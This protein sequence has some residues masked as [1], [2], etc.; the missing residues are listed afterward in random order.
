MDQ[1]SET[2]VVG[3][4][5]SKVGKIYDFESNGLADLKVGDQ[6]V[7]ETSRGWQLGQV[8]QIIVNVEPPPEGWKAIDRRA[9]PRDLLL[10]QMWQQHEAE[11]VTHAKTR[12]GELRLQGIKIIGAE[13][14]FDGS[15]LT[16]LFSSE[17]EEKYELKSLRQDMQ[18]LFA[19]SQVEMRQIG[20]RDVAKLTCGM[21]ACGLEKR[22]CCSFLTEFSSISIRM[23]KEQG[24]SLTP[25]EI[26]GMCGRLR[27]CLIYEYET[28]VDA[29]QTLPKRNKRVRTPKGEGKVIDVAPL[30][31]T[32]VVDLPEVGYTEFPLS[33]IVVLDEKGEPAPASTAG[34]P[35]MSPGEVADVAHSGPEDGYTG[36]A[37]E[38]RPA[39]PRSSR[40]SQEERI[41]LDS[42]PRV[43][44]P[45]KENRSQREPR[46][47]DERARGSKGSGGGRGREQGGP[48]RDQ[49]NRPARDPGSSQRGEGGQRRDAGGAQP[50]AGNA[51]RGAGDAQRDPGN[52]QRDAG[53]SQRG[54]GGGRSDSRRGPRRSG[55][56]QNRGPQG[57][58]PQAG[59][60]AN[61]GQDASEK[62]PSTDSG[63][64]GQAG[65]GPQRPN[66]A[67]R[68]QGSQG[69]R[70]LQRRNRRQR[71]SNGPDNN[72]NTN[73]TD[74][75]EN[76][77]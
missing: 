52:S 12:S 72:T 1:I 24:I 20:P 39:M 69:G 59:G 9:T 65:Q 44:I 10:R 32:V 48:A 74:N 76:R 71:G 7:V 55:S 56:S 25:T 5:F 15:R 22:C 43:E 35:A 75:S 26:T 38:A 31:G 51:Q 4:R 17:T 47:R 58:A 40:E 33:D 64:G 28:Y 53:N 60:Q 18:K 19:P 16:V 13:Y 8:A 21:G 6:V 42:A 45:P 77:A 70:D 3:V 63:T 54:P 27:C 57:P 68:E 34:R 41:D 61:S 49:A 73:N 46:P 23:A 11:V 36:K 30:R 50:P 67:P 2:M 29:R 66:R 14:S 62:P 37:P